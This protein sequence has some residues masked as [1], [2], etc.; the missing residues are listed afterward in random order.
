MAGLWHLDQ[1]ACSGRTTPTG[2]DGEC[3]FRQAYGTDDGWLLHSEW[4]KVAVNVRTSIA[5]HVTPVLVTAERATWVV[6]RPVHQ[7]M[8]RLW[9]TCAT[10]TLPAAPR[11]PQKRSVDFPPGPLGP[12]ELPWSGGGG[13]GSCKDARKMWSQH[14]GQFPEQG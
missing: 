2:V 1:P 7:P 12:C 6:S 5:N 8:D 4:V 9:V 14:S 11:F 3:A 10:A 13:G